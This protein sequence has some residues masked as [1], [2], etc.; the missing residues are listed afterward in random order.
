MNLP[1]TSEA[2]L[3]AVEEA[4]SDFFHTYGDS[5]TTLFVSPDLFGRI[6]DNHR[7]A[8]VTDDGV[9]RVLG[10]Q[11]ILAEIPGHPM[12]VGLLHDP[13]V[14]CEKCRGL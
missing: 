11:L 6:P 9:R 4:R 12:C 2:F 14:E 1:E 8:V 3:A 7:V 10:L 13:F 5:A